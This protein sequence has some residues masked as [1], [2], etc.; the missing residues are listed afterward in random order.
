MT[1][2]TD[3]MQ[4]ITLANETLTDCVKRLKLCAFDE[5]EFNSDTPTVLPE[6]ELLS[7]G[8]AIS[9]DPEWVAENFETVED[10]DENWTELTFGL[11]IDTETIAT[12]YAT[13]NAPKIQIWVHFQS[14]ESVGKLFARLV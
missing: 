4:A 3:L 7:L 9:S 10:M 14:Y 2:R 12:I 1:S 5:W 13:E 6:S 11:D 8:A